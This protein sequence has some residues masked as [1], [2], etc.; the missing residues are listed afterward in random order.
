MV[1]ASCSK[2]SEDSVVEDFNRIFPDH[3][4]VSILPSEGD[5]D[6]VYYQV[7]FKQKNSD[8][9]EEI[10]FL[11]QRDLSDSSWILIG[12]NVNDVSRKLSK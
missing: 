10:V 1:T 11:Y 8:E 7:R 3:D 12:T 2:V 5:A 4:L 6:N 9:V